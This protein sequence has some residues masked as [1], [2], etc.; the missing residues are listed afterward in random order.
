MR[1]GLAAGEDDLEVEVEVAHDGLVEL[2][3]GRVGTEELALAARLRGGELVGVLVEVLVVEDVRVLLGEPRRHEPADDPDVALRAEVLGAAVTL[4]GEELLLQVGV[5]PVLD[6]D[7]DLAGAEAL[8]GDVLLQVL[9]VDRAAQLVLGDGADDVGAGLVADP[10]VDGHVELTAV[11]TAGGGLLLVG[12]GLLVDGPSA[13]AGGE[14]HGGDGSDRPESCPPAS[15]NRH[16]A[17]PLSA[18]LV[19]ENSGGSVAAARWAGAR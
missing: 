3:V 1:G 9:V 2:D 8:P 11:T 17:S 12:L 16:A 19:C 18:V 13:A 6:H 7:V 10:R 5:T 15:G 4:V 14:R